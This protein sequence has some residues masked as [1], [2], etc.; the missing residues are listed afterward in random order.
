MV[1]DQFAKQ[2]LDHVCGEDGRGMERQP[3]EELHADL[4]EFTVD[5]FAYPAACAGRR[6]YG[7][8]YLA[9]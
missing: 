6:G 4:A 2:P 7:R 9:G 8:Q 1:L 3:A 5:V